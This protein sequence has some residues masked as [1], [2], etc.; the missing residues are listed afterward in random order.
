MSNN[1]FASYWTGLVLATCLDLDAVS[2]AVVWVCIYSETVLSFFSVLNLLKIYFLTF[3]IPERCSAKFGA[4]VGRGVGRGLDGCVTA[5]WIW[6]CSVLWVANFLN[7]SSTEK[8][9]MGI[10]TVVQMQAI[11]SSRRSGGIEFIGVLGIFWGGMNVSALGFVVCE[12]NG[13][14]RREMIFSFFFFLRVCM[15]L[16]SLKGPECWSSSPC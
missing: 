11:L 12:W 3:E 2:D 5:H 9:T 6:K 8:C 10:H 1:G 4:G 15:Y 7:T 14:V 13:V 16:F